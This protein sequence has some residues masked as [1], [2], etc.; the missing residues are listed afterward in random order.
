MASPSASALT[1][2]PSSPAATATAADIATAAAA[3]DGYTRLLV[4]GDWSAAYALLAP[5][6]RDHYGSLANFTYERAAYFKSVA[7]RYTVKIP[8]PA[9][10]GSI[11]DWL[12][13]TYGTSV[14]LGHTV[15]VE[16]D[17]PALA[18]NN[19]G[20]GLYLVAPGSGGL[21]IFDVR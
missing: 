14:D 17:Y 2:A 18:G 9:D 7:G 6:S 20:Y 12:P 4:K 10:V 5:A 19:A 11:T 3:V 16:V 13:D 15:L 8:A 21:L 1:A